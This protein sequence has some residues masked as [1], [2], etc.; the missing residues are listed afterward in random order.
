MKR[1]KPERGN[2]ILIGFMATGNSAIGR[3]LAEQD[4]GGN[5]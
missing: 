1:R 5:I 3:M 2:I 4:G